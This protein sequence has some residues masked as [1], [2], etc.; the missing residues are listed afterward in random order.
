MPARTLLKKNQDYNLD[1]IFA[2]PETEKV[3]AGKEIKNA[4][5]ADGK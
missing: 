2:I 3:K 5:L 1:I 4:V